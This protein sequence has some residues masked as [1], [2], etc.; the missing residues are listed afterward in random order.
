MPKA[1]LDERM[2]PMEQAVPSYKRRS[3]L[4]NRAPIGWTA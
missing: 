3:R 4:V 2:G 1:T